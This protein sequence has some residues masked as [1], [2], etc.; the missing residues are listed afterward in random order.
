MAKKKNT[1]TVGQK[2]WLV[3]LGNNWDSKM[4]VKESI[5]TEGGGKNF[6]FR[7]EGY[8]SEFDVDSMTS[9]ENPLL[10]EDR[11]YLSEQDALDYIESYRTVFKLREIFDR[12]FPI[13]LSVVQLR[14][15]MD[16]INNGK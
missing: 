9:G 11:C 10:N 6:M 5:I 15:I 1:I 7:V 14:K 13:N 12:E 3:P 4:K 2:V 8:G 16:I